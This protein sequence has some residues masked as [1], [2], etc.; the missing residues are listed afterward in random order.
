[1]S[2]NVTV[3]DDRLR[4]ANNKNERGSEVKRE[5]R[6]WTVVNIV[7]IVALT[8]LFPLHPSLESHPRCHDAARRVPAIFHDSKLLALRKGRWLKA[9]CSLQIPLEKF[10][11]ES[12]LSK[13]VSTALFSICYLLYWITS[14]CYTPTSSVPAGQSAIFAWLRL[15]FFLPPPLPSSPPTDLLRRKTS[16]LVEPAS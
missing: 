6:A 11:Q 15:L 3:S 12:Q 14:H 8:K 7:Y 13:P 10:Q 5:S 2:F 4:T 1:M 16:A 9:A